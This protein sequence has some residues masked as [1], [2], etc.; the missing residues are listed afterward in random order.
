MDAVSYTRFG[1]SMALVNALIGFAAGWINQSQMRFAIHGADANVQAAKTVALLVNVVV[2][3]L[4]LAMWS[5]MSLHNTWLAEG[6]LYTA[7]LCGLMA[8]ADV[9]AIPRPGRFVLMELMRALALVAT[10]GLSIAWVGALTTSLALMCFATSYVVPLV[11]PLSTRLRNPTRNSSGSLSWSLVSKGLKQWW[12]YGW[13]VGAWIC[14][15]SLMQVVDRMVVEAT[16]GASA[17]AQY[18]AL[19]ELYFRGVSL[20]LFPAV[21]A[22][23]PEIIRR[24][25][26]GHRDTALSLTRNVGLIQVALLA[27]LVVACVITTGWAGMALGMPVGGGVNKWLVAEFVAAAVIWQLVLIVHKP[28]ELLQRTGLMLAF[29]VAA[30]A[31]F[32][33]SL[34]FFR[35]GPISLIPAAYITSGLAYLLLCLFSFRWVGLTST[36]SV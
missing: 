27:P 2:G 35:G 18:I 22:S 14:V 9:L 34:W 7:M 6:L 31:V 8:A 12:L 4:A 26:A 21:M 33:I 29:A 15:T 10:I 1:Q 5:W 17:S 19:F 24:W 30:F 16:Y 11:L 32:L 25:T 3:S 13:P 20:V 23:Y 28:L 36:A